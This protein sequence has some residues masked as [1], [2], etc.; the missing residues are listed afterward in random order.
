MSFV[1]VV[2]QR[3]KPLD[4]VHPGRA[5]F[6][7]KSGYAAV[8]RRYPFT[9]IMKDEKQD[10]E[11]EPLRIKID[12]GSKTT[13]LAVVNDATG[14]VV[15]AAELSHRG[16]RVKENL[17]KR[18]ACRRSRR[19]RHTR[20]RKP[21]FLNRKRRKGWLPPSLDSR[22]QNILTWVERIRKFCPIGALSQ[23]LV[24]FDTQLLEHPEISG[25]EYQQGTCA[26]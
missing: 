17:D 24:R 6:L 12:P 5:R 9:I 25:I 16:Q 21:R 23:E 20:Y 19:Q 11:P 8:L 18:R 1:F 22:I 26:T 10:I 3:R 13:G 15:W 4:P 7:L 14:Q 2:N